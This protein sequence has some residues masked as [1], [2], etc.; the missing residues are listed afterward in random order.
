MSSHRGI[1]GQFMFV[2]LD[3][4]T[5]RRIVSLDPRH[6]DEDLRNGARSGALS[7]PECHQLVIFRT[8][9]DL[10]RRHF[11]HKHRVNCPFGYERP[12]LIEARAVLYEWAI[13]QLS[14]QVQIEHRPADSASLPRPIDI[15]VTLPEGHQR[16]FWIFDAPIRNLETREAIRHYFFDTRSIS[17]TWMFLTTALTTTPNS[18]S[19]ILLSKMMRDF[20]VRTRYEEIRPSSDGTLH[21]L[22]IETKQL[23][24]F[25]RLQRIHAPNIYKGDIYTNDMTALWVHPKSLEI[26]HPGEHDLLVKVRNQQRAERAQRQNTAQWSPPSVRISSKSAAESRKPERLAN[27]SHSMR[28]DRVTVR[29]RFCGEM[30]NEA[31]LVEWVR[32]NGEG[33]CRSCMRRGR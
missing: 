14:D 2:A 22:D 33:T 17:A 32:S 24:T 3:T 10:K 23:T 13:S 5:S 30:K 16:A 18:R 25:R 12:E 6:S 9:S 1:V 31:E 20:I 8:G 11:A 27:N 19:E 7:C 4:R 21:Y 26:A 28:R 29:C 15:L